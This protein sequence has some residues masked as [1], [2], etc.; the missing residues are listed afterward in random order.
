MNQD[1]IEIENEL[2]KLW[3]NL[4]NSIMTSILSANNPE[5]DLHNCMVCKASVQDNCLMF[6]DKDGNLK[7]AEEYEDWVMY[8]VYNYLCQISL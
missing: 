4:Y 1:S 3:C 2:S 5:I 7:S 6:T 8:S